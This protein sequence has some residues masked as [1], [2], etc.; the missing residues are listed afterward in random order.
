MIYIYET[1]DHLTD[2]NLWLVFLEQFKGFTVE[3]FKKIH[4]DLRSKLQRH[5]LKR[6]VYVGKCS[7]RVIISEQLFKVIQREELH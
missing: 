3:S 4:T 7:N 2:N 6:G 5:L 1:Q